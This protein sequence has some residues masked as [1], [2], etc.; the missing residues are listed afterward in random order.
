MYIIICGKVFLNIA[1]QNQ[2]LI[3]FLVCVLVV[4][5]SRKSNYFSLQKQGTK[6]KLKTENMYCAIPGIE[7]LPTS[8]SSHWTIKPVCTYYTLKG[9]SLK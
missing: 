3:F 2:G 1:I 5:S 7:E 9:T 8:P 6:K 4:V